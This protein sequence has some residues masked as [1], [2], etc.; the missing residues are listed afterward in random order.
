MTILN[1]KNQITAI[2]AVFLICVGI[3]ASS[4]I[5]SNTNFYI[6]NLGNTTDQN[7]KLTNSISVTGDGKIYAKPDM[8]QLEITVSEIANTSDQ[9]L[10]NANQKLD[11]VI[12]VLKN[13]GINSED[14]KTTQLS[15]SPEY[16]YTQSS[17]ILK[18]QRAIISVNTKIKHLD[19]KAT[20]ATQI[21][22][23]VS[24]IDNIQI[25]SIYFD[26][27]DKTPLFTQARK[28]AM[29][30]AKQKALELS[31][32]GEVKLL[33]PLSITDNNYEVVPSRIY[34][35]TNSNSLSPQTS[36]N[37]TQAGGTVQSG[38]LEVNA[39]ITVIYSIQ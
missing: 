33:A 9:A 14:I 39:N 22:D 28:L 26:V 5:L 12:S 30:K 15:L 27:E 4:I 11:Q 3:I 21:I 24:K 32:F 19:D 36:Q 13:K 29:D 23:E 17:R 31:K 2:V 38:Q 16:D 34:S 7:G 37:S 8:A 25:G 20:K 10:R 6:K 1:Y 18:G 35:V